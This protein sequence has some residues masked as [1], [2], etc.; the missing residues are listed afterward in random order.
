MPKVHYQTNRQLSILK[1]HFW[2]G[3]CEPLFKLC[4]L[5]FYDKVFKKIKFYVLPHK[6]NI[7]KK[8]VNLLFLNSKYCN[9]K[10][11]SDL[12]KS[13]QGAS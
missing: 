11:P 6:P 1:K 9:L 4:F 8:C 7:L 13:L 5:K 12:L 10:V 3:V 2:P